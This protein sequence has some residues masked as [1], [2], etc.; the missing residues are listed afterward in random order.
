VNPRLRI[1]V[2]LLFSWLLFPSAASAQTA[3]PIPDLPPYSAIAT[4]TTAPPTG[5]QPTSPVVIPLTGDNVEEWE[6]MVDCGPAAT[7]AAGGSAIVFDDGEH[8]LTTRAKENGIAS[9]TRWIDRTVRIDATA[10]FN[11]TVPPTTAWQKGPVYVP[12]TASDATSPVST[13]YRIDGGAWTPGNNAMINGTGVHT[14]E[15]AAVDAAGNRTER[16]DTVRID[17]ELPV[18]TTEVAPD[19]DV[20][21]DGWHDHAVSVPVT[22]T[23]ADSDVAKVE[24]QLDAQA[25]GE[26]PEGTVILVASHGIHTLRTR[27]TD[28]AG[29]VTPWKNTT[30]KVNI[31]GPADTTVVPTDWITEPS[32]DIDI[33]AEPNGAAIKRIEW[34][35]DGVTSGEEWYTETVPVTVTGDGVHELEVRITDD[36]DKVNDWHTHL[37]K[38]DTVNPVDNTTVA[39]GW[40]PLAYLDVIVRG[41][42]EHS[43]VRGVEWRLDGGD[44]YTES[45]NNHEVRVTGNGVH[46]LETRIVD[47]AGRKSGWKA[48]TIRL[49]SA[50]PTNTTPAYPGGW[51]NT[52]YSVVLDGTDAGAGVN[53]VNWRVQLE[54]EPAGDEYEGTPKVTQVTIDQ[55]GTHTLSTR[56]LDLAGNYSAWRNETIRIDRVLPTD[57]TVYPTAPVPN[58]HTITF[59]ANDD[60]SG[61]AYVEYKRDDDPVRTGASVQIRGEGEHTLS[62]RVRDN[63]GNYSAWTE[64]KVTV[65]FGPDT[66][67][68]TDLTEVPSGWQLAPTKVVL[69]ATDDDEDRPGLLVQW[70]TDDDSVGQA[71]P[72]HELTFSADGEHEFETRAVDASGRSTEWRTHTLRIDTT[73][74]VD[75]TT[76]KGPYTND[77]A[78]TLQAT[79]A[80]SGVDELEYRLNNGGTVKVPNGTVVTLPSDGKHR[81]AHRALDVAG[82]ASAWKVDEVTLDRVAPANTSPAVPTGWQ[83]TALSLPLS[84][85]DALSGVARTE[86]RVNGKTTAGATATVTSEG[87]Q[88]FE[89]R[90]VDKAGNASPWRSETI[91]IDRTPPV[92]TTPAPASPWRNSAYVTTVT[93]TDTVSGLATVQY[94]LGDGGIVNSPAVSISGEG[95]YRLSTR[96]VDVAGN[97]SAWR[98]DTIGIDMT[99]PTLSADCGGAAWRNTPALCAV[100]ASGGLSG[101][102]ALTATRDG[103]PTEAIGPQYAVETEGAMTVTFRAVDGAGNAKTATAALKIDRT[104][105]T[106]NVRCNAGT[107]GW[108][109]TPTTV[110]G[111]S[112]VASV[113]YAVDGGAPVA[114]PSG[115]S[116]TVKKGKV[117]VSAT[118]VAGNTG[119]S[120]PVT[121]AART[122]TDAG[123]EVPGRTASEAIL[124][125]KRAKSSRLLGQLAIAATSTRTTV[126]LR[127]LALGKGTF[128]FV[129]KVK[130]DKKT[131][132]FRKT[133]RTRRGYSKRFSVSTGA[134]VNVSV[135]VTVR[136]KVGKRWKTH[137]SGKAT[138]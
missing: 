20:D 83:R 55:D 1:F 48:H 5:W 112:G 32:A 72:P 44:V 10:P 57:D 4:D 117:V 17:N 125:G 7:V 88:T 94:K 100:N 96:V 38:I 77:P 69:K 120:A 71:T 122:G 67:D 25:P 102:Q 13:E 16:N 70:R 42:D 36:N 89:T 103:G 126:D 110:D 115:G 134:G 108:T 123:D 75:T 26:G 31:E 53:S 18:D 21:P 92:N 101:L 37:V 35:L 65:E 64:H 136:K 90:V 111:L 104:P 58:R 82:Q 56:V 60:R 39:A 15:S 98:A 28:K 99:P 116:F 137:A 81:I 79:D 14:L 2:V 113:A 97:A 24:W 119:T 130:T 46:T 61:V 107:D 41:A 133:Q 135:T 19:A 8:V 6:Y 22:G 80:T 11:T 68:P 50:L 95:T 27:V 33:T 12:L 23:D 78:I 73:K 106:V 85:T 132:T 45:Q 86:W 128:Q 66:T 114:V 124:L 138:L 59:D 76:I 131:K 54:G 51:R 118:D 121:L 9:W 47:H 74:P 49:D 84:G 40:H 62:V 127:P 34:R 30:V 129:V 63:A 52:P 109:C 93:G 3:C 43:Q 29:N 105:P 91:R 87:V